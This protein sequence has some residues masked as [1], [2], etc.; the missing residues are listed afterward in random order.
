MNLGKLELESRLFLVSRYFVSNM[1]VCAKNLNCDLI[2]EYHPGLLSLSDEYQLV[3][4][5]AKTR[6]IT[7]FKDG[8]PYS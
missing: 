1:C 4:L 7:S 8:N 3:H 6:K 2:L 5:T